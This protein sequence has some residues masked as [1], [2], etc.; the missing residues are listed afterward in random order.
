VECARAQRPAVKQS[1]TDFKSLAAEAEE[2]SQQNRLDDAARLYS[3]ALALR[4][5]WAEGWWALGTL[6]YDQNHY[7]K[8]ATDLE[9]LIALQPENGTAHAMLGL[10]EFE[11]H[12]DQQALRDLKAAT[13]MGVVNEPNLHR[14]T[15]YHLAVL[16]LSARKFGNAEESLK[17]LMETGAENAELPLLFGEAALQ[18]RP[19]DAPNEGSPGRNVLLRAGT[20]EMLKFLKKFDKGK[21][22]FLALVLEYPDYPN[23]RFACGR[24]LLDASEPD[25]AVRQFQEELRRNPGNVNALLEIAAVRY[26]TDSADGVKYAEQAVKA[27]PRHPFAHY[28][29][30]LLYLDTGNVTGASSELEIAQRGFPNQPEVYFALGNAYARAGRKEEA[31]KARATFLRL[32]K[33]K[34][35]DDAGTVGEQPSGLEQ[36]RF[37]GEKTPQKNQPQ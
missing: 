34:K 18:I 5:K 11:L 3:R 12:K 31:A 30:G 1:S 26:R 23:L 37:G 14:V 28:L 13:R 19:E 33:E 27:N 20:A 4:P 9:K 10:C 32:S 8:A 25:E 22:E 15:L 35:T 7:A 2:A 17:L 21:Q 36:G 6:E 24:F 16:Q 29:L